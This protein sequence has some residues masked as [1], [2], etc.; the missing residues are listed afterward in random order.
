MLNAR[1]V[2]IWRQR[3]AIVTKTSRGQRETKPSKHASSVDIALSGVNLGFH[4][5]KIERDDIYSYSLITRF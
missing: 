4:Y 3:A 2:T 5:A 1:I